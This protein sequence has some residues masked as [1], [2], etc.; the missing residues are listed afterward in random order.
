MMAQITEELSM[1][2]IKIF[3]PDA[4][5]KINAADR[6]AFE[7][8]CKRY[9]DDAGLQAKYGHVYAFLG[10]NG[11]D[12]PSYLMDPPVARP[13]VEA[14]LAK[15]AAAN[16]LNAMTDEEKL[17]IESYAD[18]WRISADIRNEFRS[19]E[20][21]A[22]YMRASASGLVKHHGFGTCR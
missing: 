11:V 15:L 20:S 9:R 6:A 3:G 4:P 12:V 18:R 8:L 7:G 17:K 10:A 5:E 2:Q 13:D 22:A 16:P 14:Y 1:T 21:Y 19:F